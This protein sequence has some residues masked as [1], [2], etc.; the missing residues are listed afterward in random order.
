MMRLEAP[1][2]E[3]RRLASGQAAKDL[4]AEELAWIAYREKSCLFY[5]YNESGR[6]G[7]AID[8][9]GR[10]GAVIESA[11]RIWSVSART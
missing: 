5:A 4:L 7:Q 9:P 3:T 1:W 2:K 10:R 8:F 6:Q 11:P